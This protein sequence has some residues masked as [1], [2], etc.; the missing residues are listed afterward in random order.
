VVILNTVVN[1]PVL[2]NVLSSLSS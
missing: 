2:H 1:R